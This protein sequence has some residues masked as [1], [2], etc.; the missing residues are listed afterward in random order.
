M[1]GN[2]SPSIKSCEHTLNTL[3]YADRVKELKESNPNK[4]HNKADRLMLSRNE[5]NSERIEILKP[6]EDNHL[7][8]EVFD[9]KK[10]NKNKNNLMPIKTSDSKKELT[11]NFFKKERSSNQKK[12]FLRRPKSKSPIIQKY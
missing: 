1:I 6:K 12:N 4:K 10:N 5:K 8:F 7:V 3:R 11:T 2:I 9:V